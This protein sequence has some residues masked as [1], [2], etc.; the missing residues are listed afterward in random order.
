[1]ET[2]LPDAMGTAVKWKRDRPDWKAL[3]K[4]LVE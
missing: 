2:S 3:R 4:L 1:L